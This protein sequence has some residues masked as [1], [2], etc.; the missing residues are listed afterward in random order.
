MKN[1]LYKIGITLTLLL[2]LSCDKLPDNGNLDG[3]WQLMAVENRASG[4]CTDWSG[5]QRYWSFRLRLVQYSTHQGISKEVLY[6]HF[7]QE[8]SILWLTDFCTAAKYEKEADDNEWL[9]PDDASRLAPWGFTP[10]PDPAAHTKTV[11]T[12]QIEQL[13]ASTLVLSNENV[14]LTFRKF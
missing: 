1:R 14:I 2:V 3:M 10:L 13:S 11:A 9:T 8:G 12:F 5:N 7:E 6:A 4:E